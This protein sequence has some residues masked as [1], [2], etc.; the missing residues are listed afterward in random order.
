MISV[1]DLIFEITSNAIQMMKNTNFF[2][3]ISVWSMLLLSLGFF[4]LELILA[5]IFGHKGDD[6]A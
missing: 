2:Y 4:F 6:K 3:G 1:W 5:T